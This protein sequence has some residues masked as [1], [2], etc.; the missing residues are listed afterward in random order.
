M[1]ID[2]WYSWLL[3]RSYYLAQVIFIVSFILL[4]IRT[5]KITAY[6]CLFGFVLFLFGNVLMLNADSA[7]AELEQTNG[8][9]GVAET[10]YLIGRL[11]S[12]LGFVSA[13]FGLLFFARG[14][15]EKNK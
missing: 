4:A 15:K 10:E 8:E 14:Y 5:K 1:E 13:G 2:T 3:F 6:I 11:V 9:R 12:S 7:L